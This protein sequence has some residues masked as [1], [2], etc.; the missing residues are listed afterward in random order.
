MEYTMRYVGDH[1]ERMQR[2]AQLT[3]FKLPSPYTNKELLR[4]KIE[5]LTKEKLVQLE[6]EVK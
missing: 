2:L 3:M 5:R 4:A 1:P 6:S